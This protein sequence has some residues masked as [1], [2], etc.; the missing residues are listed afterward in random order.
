MLKTRQSRQEPGTG[1]GRLLHEMRE[2][3]TNLPIWM[4]IGFLVAEEEPE[5]ILT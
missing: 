2:L 4:L 1:E 3:G 5:G